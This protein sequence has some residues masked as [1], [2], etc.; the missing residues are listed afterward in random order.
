M[1]DLSVQIARSMGLADISTFG[2]PRFNLGSMDGL[3]A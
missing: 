3:R 1:A 2:D